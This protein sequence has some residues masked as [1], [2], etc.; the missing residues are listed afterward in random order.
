[1]KNIKFFESF[2]NENYETI[3]EGHDGG[4]GKAPGDNKED[5]MKQL[6]EWIDSD[7]EEED[8]DFKKFSGVKWVG[9][10]SEEK[11]DKLASQYEDEYIILGEVDGELT[12]AYWR[13]S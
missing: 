11:L 3:N 8:G 12:Y 7:V 9:K 1:M 4:G 6:Q 13:R 5:A 10:T 2:V